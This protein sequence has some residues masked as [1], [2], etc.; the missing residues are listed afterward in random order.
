M[1]KKLN[2]N[3]RK[4]VIP[5]IVVIVIIIILA[6]TVRTVDTGEVAVVTQFGVVT[7]TEGA[8]I[9]IKSPLEEY[10]VISVKQEQVDEI[11]YTATKDTQS[12][13]QQIVTQLAVD[14]T[15]CKS[16][17]EK[18]TGNHL[19]GIVKP[20]LYDGFKSAT[21]AFTLEGAIAQRD[22]LAA[23]MLENVKSK[24]EPYGIIVVS[25]E[26]KDVQIPE[27]FAQAV[28]DK[29]VAEQIQ[30]RAETEKLTAI[31]KAEQEL[32]VKKLEAEANT[33]VTQTLSEQILRQQFITKWDGKLPLYSGN[34]GA[35]NMLLPA[36]QGAA[37]VE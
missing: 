35:L 4:I 16:L 23:K 36:T 32:E 12:I 26:I 37:V 13:N 6:M 30:A 34:D 25:V 17:Y 10:H 31:I 28:E 19:E 3:G 5:I 21:A 15:S 18:F 9:H 27:A 7:G 33:I 1:K 29:K 8:G 11:Y 24:L 22:A 20:V 2:R 14:P